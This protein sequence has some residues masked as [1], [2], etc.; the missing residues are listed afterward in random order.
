ME[1]ITPSLINLIESSDYFKRILVVES[2]EYIDALRE[3]F[4]FA[5]I[6]FVTPDEDVAEKFSAQV[7]VFVMDYREERLPF[8]AEFFDA[9]VGDL[10]LEVVGNPQDIATGFLTYLNPTGVWLTSFRNLR[11]WKVLEKLMQGHYYGVFARLY[12]KQDFDLILQASFYKQI[13]FFPLIKKAPS[14]MLDRLLEC[15]FENFGDDLETEFWLVCAERS[16]PELVLLKSMYTTEIRAE[17][18]RIIHRIEYNIDVELSVKKF[19][20]IYDAAGMFAEYAINFIDEVVVHREN[21]Y[22]NFE[23]YSARVEEIRRSFL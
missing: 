14:E 1:K 12:T 7:K 20:E 16:M 15:G 11:H 22:T 23:K 8:D 13:K 17:F 18:S 3:K 9:I 10:T 5:E 2:S 6:F 21:F 4:H 19:W